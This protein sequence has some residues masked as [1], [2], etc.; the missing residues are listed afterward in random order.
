MTPTTEKIYQRHRLAFFGW[1]STHE[2]DPVMASPKTIETYLIGVVRIS[3]GHGTVAQILAALDG[4]FVAHGVDL[5][6]TRS[7]RVRAIKTILRCAPGG[8][9]FASSEVRLLLNACPRSLHGLRDRALI[10]FVAST[11]ARSSRVASLTA[12]EY[13][14]SDWRVH[15]VL[16]WLDAAGISSGPVFRSFRLGRGMTAQAI[17]AHSVTKIIKKRSRLAGIDPTLCNANS[18]LGAVASGAVR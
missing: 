17:C 13:H 12:E 11:R 4:W 14:A 10:A 3:P 7:E 5:P 2:I 15:E 16:E 9:R 8:I 6:P 18:L 1:C